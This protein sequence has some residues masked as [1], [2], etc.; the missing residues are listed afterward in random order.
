MGRNTP[1]GLIIYPNWIPP[2]IPKLRFC[3]TLVF[4]EL[5]RDIPPLKSSNGGILPVSHKNNL[6]DKIALILYI[7]AS[8]CTYYQLSSVS[9]RFALITITII[10]I[11]FLLTLLCSSWIGTLDSGLDAH[12]AESWMIQNFIACKYKYVIY[13]YY[14]PKQFLSFIF[15]DHSYWRS[16]ATL[17]FVEIH[18]YP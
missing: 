1:N 7:S 12:P 6:M 17:F 8:S 14:K 18:Q 15:Y 11:I 3:R 9:G 5:G 10:T 2:V 16:Q 13:Y 4:R